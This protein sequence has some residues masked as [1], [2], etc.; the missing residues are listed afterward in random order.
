MEGFFAK[1]SSDSKI[2]VRIAESCYEKIILFRK[3]REGDIF[4]IFP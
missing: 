1:K 4:W 3:E 2:M